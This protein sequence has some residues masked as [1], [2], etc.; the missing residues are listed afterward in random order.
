[1]PYKYEWYKSRYTSKFS[2]VNQEAYIYGEGYKAKFR[3]TDNPPSWP[4]SSTTHKLD[5]P[6]VRIVWPGNAQ[7]TLRSTI[8]E[9]IARVVETPEVAEIR[10]HYIGTVKKVEGMSVIAEIGPP[11]DMDRRIA[12]LHLGSFDSKPKENDEIEC[13][14]ITTGHSSYVQSKVIDKTRIPSLESLGIIREEW[15]DWASEEENLS[16]DGA[17]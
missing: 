2:E 10:Q 6:V 5:R 14:I 3:G 4:Y 9:T 13:T 15:L 7:G 1:M 16:E 12:R 17:M 8:R 11:D